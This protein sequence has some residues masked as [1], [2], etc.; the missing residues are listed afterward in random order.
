MPTFYRTSQGG[1][2]IDNG[3]RRMTQEPA[4]TDDFWR[5]LGEADEEALAVL[6]REYEAEIRRAASVRLGPLLR[7]HLDSLDL[8]QS[9]FIT[10]LKGL[11]NDK[12][13]IAG[14]HEL[15]ALSA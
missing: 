1:V 6:L 11:R 4:E 8:V 2:M 14:P 10:L 3:G 5:R 15:V 13:H 12:F 7:P 9:V